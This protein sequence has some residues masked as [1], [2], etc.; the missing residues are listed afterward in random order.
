MLCICL[1][2]LDGLMWRISYMVILFSSQR[3][4][5]ILL[6]L[7]RYYLTQ[8][9]IDVHWGLPCLCSHL[10]TYGSTALVYRGCFFSFLICTQSVGLLGWGISS[11]QGSYPHTE[12]HKHRINAHRHPYLEWDSNPRSHRSSGQRHFH[13]LDREATVIGS[14]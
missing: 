14:L 9:H 12:Q 6:K 3:D 11:S 7:R 13:A 5:L 10:S 8:S 4:V 1:L 2:S